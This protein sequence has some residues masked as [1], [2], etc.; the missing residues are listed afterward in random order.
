[1]AKVVPY[2]GTWIET[3]I[4]DLLYISIS[5][6]P[7]IGTWIETYITFKGLDDPEVVPYIG[8]WIETIVLL[9]LSTFVES[10][11]I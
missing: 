10:Y 3:V 7:Y 4:G 9:I 11:L 5:V 6:V 8:T 2:I 1:M